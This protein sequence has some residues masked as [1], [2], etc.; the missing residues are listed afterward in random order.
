MEE[1][2]SWT[3]EPPARDTAEARSRHESNRLAWNEAAT[4]Y[5][6]EIE[7]TIRFLRE[8]GSNLHPIERG[9]LGDLHAWC[10]RAI[11]LQ[12]ASGRDTLSLLNEGVREVV[13]I[14][15]SDAM[16][17]NAVATCEALGSRAR[18][19]RFIR[20]DV[21]DAPANL[22]GGFDLVYTGRGA[23]CWILDIDAWAAVVFRLLK[24][25]GLLCLFD[26]HPAT[27]LFDNE[28][29]ELVP[30]GIDYFR[31]AEISRG[32]SSGYLGDLPIPTGLQSAKHERLWP[33]GATVTALLGVGLGI[34]HLGE[35]PDP[36]YDGFPRLPPELSARLPMT[37]SILARKP[38]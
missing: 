30:T 13:G 4:R 10:R 19:A 18:S 3:T 1:T 38:A 9:M 33:I 22:D 8:G 26:S 12:C 29:A 6:E 5:A 2:P 37:F 14:D 31:H 35:H 36:Y 24:P 28:A 11:H 21:L 16:I 23:I 32:W 7:E 17:A 15:I 34:E 20:C 25:G 27:Y